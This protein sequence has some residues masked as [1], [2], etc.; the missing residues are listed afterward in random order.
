VTHSERSFSTLTLSVS[1]IPQKQIVP[2]F[3]RFSQAAVTKHYLLQSAPVK[4]SAKQED[5]ATFFA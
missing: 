5:Q 2:S 1:G 3:A 4:I